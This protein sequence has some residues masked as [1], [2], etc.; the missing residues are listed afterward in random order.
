MLRNRRRNKTGNPKLNRNKT[1]RDFKTSKDS[2]KKDLLE[3]ITPSWPF[4]GV[5]FL[6]DF[7]YRLELPRL[8]VEILRERSRSRGP[9]PG[10]A[11]TVPEQDLPEV[12]LLLNYDQLRRQMYSGKVF[13]G[14]KEVY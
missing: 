12:E 3:E 1:R 14:F 6:G 9:I 2:S 4:D 13:H 5:I 7:N 10:D 8:E 11:M